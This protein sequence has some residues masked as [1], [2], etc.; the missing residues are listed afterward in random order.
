MGAYLK[1]YIFELRFLVC[2]R[3]RCPRAW[4]V[5]IALK[6]L[7]NEHLFVSVGIMLTKLRG[8]NCDKHGGDIF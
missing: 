8:R 4:T 7:P 1:R 5:R 2:I 3:G 6:I